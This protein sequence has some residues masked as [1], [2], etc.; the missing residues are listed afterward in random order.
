MATH[1]RI[2]KELDDMAKDTS[3]GMHATPLDP[4][5][6]MH[7]QGRFK[8]PPGTPYEGGEFV[9]DIR[10]PDNYPF[11]PPKMKF[12]TKVWHPNVSSQTGAICLDTL[13]AKWSPVL[14][15]KTALLSLQSLLDA[16]EPSDPQDAEVAQMMLSAPQLFQA[17]AREW[18]VRYAGASASVA[19]AQGSSANRPIVVAEAKKEY[20]GYEETVVE[21]FASMGFSVGMVVRALGVVGVRKRGGLTEEEVVRVVELLLS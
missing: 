7:L 18:A 21:K 5:N 16:P 14:T 12:E 4:G 11:M 13:S 8:G 10:L 1:R 3:S 2:M 9:I 15:I 20:G 17:R 19:N 6:M